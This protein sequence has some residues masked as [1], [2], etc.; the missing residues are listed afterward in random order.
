M[1]GAAHYNNITSGMYPASYVA[2][3]AV[4]ADCHVSNPTNAT[5]RHQWAKSR[6]AAFTDPAWM[7]EDFKTM[8]GCVQCHTTTGFIA[9]STGKVTAA[10]G[11]A[12]DK[13]KEVLRCNGCHSNVE[14]GIVRA[15][16]PVKPFAAD[17]YVNRNVGPSNICMD[18][19][20]G[21]NNGLSITSADFTSQ[22]FIAPHY[23]AAGGIL[24]G[25]GGYNFPGQSYAFYSSNTHR[26]IGMGNNSST[27][28]DGP[29][30]G[31]HMS[32][33][34]K[35]RFKAVSSA[36]NGTVSKVTASTCANC[37]GTTLD[38][39]AIINAR[40]TSFANAL[41]VL[42]QMLAYRSFNY[43]P[44]YPYFSNT[45]WGSGQAGANSMGAAFN[46]VLLLKEPGA[47]AHNSAYAKQLT[48]DSIDYLYNGT[49]TGSIDSAVDYLVGHGITQEQAD[50]LKAYQNT[51]SCSSC[52]ANTSGSHPAHLNSGFGCVDCHSATASSNTTLIP[53]TTTHLNGVINLLPGPARSFSYSAGTCSS[54]SCHNNGSATWGT[55]LGCNGCHG[56]PPAYA[57][58]SPKANS[59]ANH[60][61]GCGTCHAGTTVDGTTISNTSLHV[62]GMYD[63]TAGA[64]ITFTY[65]YASTGGTCSNISCHGGTSA[66]WGSTGNH[67]ANL[68]SG[69]IEL[70]TIDTRHDDGQE[71]PKEN[72][73]LCHYANI[74]AQHNNDCS[75]CHSG[76]NPPVARVSKINGHW[77]QNCQSGACHPTFH[78][79]VDHDAV[80]DLTN[81]LNCHSVSNPWDYYGSTTGDNCA[82]C[83]S[84]EQTL[85]VFIQQHP[86]LVGTPP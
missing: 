37:H 26:A 21:T 35:H 23:L 63:V 60:S 24:H 50:S 14:N 49:I 58:G 85:S 39:T 4:C 1:A 84:P 18:C 19:H 74:V 42:K 53:G 34:Q 32:A 76:A 81:C 11:V 61:F 12:S 15:I 13:T 36:T 86:P 72:C 28:T 8:P 38:D 73:S 17:S 29:C 40:Q 56:Y 41:E 10:W 64:G 27:G 83:H 25:K 78:T 70:F 66:V 45:N 51:S 59:H 2:S 55:T 68:G 82:W 52:H 67:I 46:Y 7:A 71:A 16:T 3:R 47:Y 43:S 44:N 69:N 31:C 54:I 20:S 6:H 48:F 22:T 62:N 33:S 30:I 75:I 79:N 80:V 57:N 5:V 77:D 9:Y 65:T